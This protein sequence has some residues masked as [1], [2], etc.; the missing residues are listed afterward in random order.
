[1]RIENCCPQFELH[2]QQT[3][4]S[5]RKKKHELPCDLTEA[6]PQN[7]MMKPQKINFGQN[8]NPLFTRNYLIR[9]LNC[10]HTG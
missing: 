8:Y 4:V 7:F 1:M 5:A 6:E 9:Q 10:R 2:L 3:K